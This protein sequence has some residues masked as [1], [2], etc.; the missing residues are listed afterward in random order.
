MFARRE[1]SEEEISRRAYE[2]YQRRG[3]QGKD[4]E[5]WITAEK[6]LSDEPVAGL[7]KT[8]AAQQARNIVN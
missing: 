5:D 1:P 3:E 4:V 7:P 2:L 8:R 6:E